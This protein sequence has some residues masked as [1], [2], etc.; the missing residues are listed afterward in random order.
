MLHPLKTTHCRQ[1]QQQQQQL[2]I[3]QNLKPIFYFVLKLPLLTGPFIKNAKQ[4]CKSY[5][6]L[7]QKPVS[8]PVSY[9]ARQSITKRQ[10]WW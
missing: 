8:I 2:T 1:Q 6:Y 9:M 10:F 5:F 7:S 4:K 3:P